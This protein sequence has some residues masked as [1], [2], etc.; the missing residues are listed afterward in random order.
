MNSSKFKYSESPEILIM[1]PFPEPR[2]YP[3]GW[4]FGGFQYDNQT[5]ALH[6]LPS[7]EPKQPVP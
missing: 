7:T 2:T 5:P 6:I 1:D 3:A 4:D